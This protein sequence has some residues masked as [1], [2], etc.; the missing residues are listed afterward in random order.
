MLISLEKYT[1]AIKA[2]WK[3][4]VVCEIDFLLFNL[5]GGMELTGYLHR[6]IKE[7]ATSLKPRGKEVQVH[8]GSQLCTTD[9]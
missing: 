9:V 8:P 2:V 3:S 1:R 7:A 5:L 4:T 6:Q